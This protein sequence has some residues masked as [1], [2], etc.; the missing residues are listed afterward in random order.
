ME[1]KFN[2]KLKSG[3]T[4]PVKAQHYKGKWTVY[5]GKYG[6]WSET[7]FKKIGDCKSTDDIADLIKFEFGASNIKDISIK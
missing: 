2:V 5:A 1:K 6:F 4:R 7:G 3:G